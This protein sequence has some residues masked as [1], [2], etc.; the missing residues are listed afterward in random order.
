MSRVPFLDLA[1]LHESIRPEIDAALDR[2]IRGSS[3]VGG[4]EVDQQ[5]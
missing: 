4:D 1:R 5:L 2:V 3:F